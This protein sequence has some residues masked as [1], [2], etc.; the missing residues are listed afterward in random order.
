MISTVKEEVVSY[1]PLKLTV[2]PVPV[3]VTVAAEE[4]SE[5]GVTKVLDADDVHDPL[6]EV[7]LLDAFGD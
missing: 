1:K 5:F 2:A 6:E 4:Q 3:E 7:E